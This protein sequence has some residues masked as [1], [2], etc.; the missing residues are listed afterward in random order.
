M[1]LIGTLG[2]WTAGVAGLTVAT[3]AGLLF[4][5]QS[6]LVYPASFP[7]GSRTMVDTPDM[8]KMPF[9]EHRILTPDRV[10]LHVYA[11]VHDDD[12]SRPTVLMFHANAGNMGHR[13]P[14]AQQF[15]R[16]MGCHVVM[17]SYRGYGLSTGHPTEMGL[18][19]DAQTLLDWVLAHP[20]LSRTQLVVYGQSIGGAVAIDLAARNPRTVGGD[21]LT[22][23]RGVVV[24]NTYAAPLTAASSASPRSCPPC[25]RCCARSCSCAVRCVSHAPRRG[26]AIPRVRGQGAQ[27]QADAV[28]QRHERRTHPCGAHEG[29][30]PPGDQRAQ[31]IPRICYGH[32]Q[33][34][35]R[36]TPDDTWLEVRRR[37]HAE[38]IL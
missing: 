25:C 2:R 1:G 17:L 32:A 14:I 24:E 4:V 36:L 22:Q 18:R 12:A 16:R 27:G 8:Y 34:V 15:Y 38:N 7:E 11:M 20:K 9:T 28:P 3:A 37:T 31:R 30:V 29:A 13:L 26:V 19:I 10:A 35:A 21:A 23:I 5:Y 6:A 33:Y